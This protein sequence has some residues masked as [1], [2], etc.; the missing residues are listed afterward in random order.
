MGSPGG[1]RK[2]MSKMKPCIW[3]DLNGAL[4]D[5]MLLD[6]FDALGARKRMPWVFW[7]S[8][9]VKYISKEKVNIEENSPP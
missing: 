7:I 6:V 1:R 8:S 9:S 2:K 5:C 4:G 3:L